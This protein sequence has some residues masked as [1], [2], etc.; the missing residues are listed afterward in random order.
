MRRDVW[1]TPRVRLESTPAIVLRTR[2]YGES[3]KIVTVLSRAAGKFSGIAKGAKRS[4]RRFPGTLE[5]FSH[6]TLDYKRRPHSEL[7]FLDRAVLLQPWPR[8]L[9]TLE[10]FT[11]ASHVVE[12]ADKMTVESEVGDDLYGLV[13]STLNRLNAAEPG[14]ATLRL[15]ELAALNASG[16]RPELLVCRS[17]TR[18]LQ[19]DRGPVRLVGG[20]GGALCSQ[21][22]AREEGGMLLSNDAL[23]C[24]GFLQAAVAQAGLGNGHDARGMQDDHDAP[25]PWMIEDVVAARL[26]SRAAREVALAL[27][28]LLS[29]HLRGRLRSLELLGPV[30]N[31]HVTRGDA[32]R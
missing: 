8:L 27:D 10:R 3:D 12:L 31:D 15:F 1:Y 17:C 19:S 5:V 6:V 23:E 22:R 32:S 9:N 29:P 16:Y 2:E 25:D 28:L 4:Q 13:A 14:P 21:C 11:C 26:T 18:P 30:L 20:L 7:A 24:L